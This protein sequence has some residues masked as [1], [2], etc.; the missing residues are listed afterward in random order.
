MLAQI[1]EMRDVISDL[2][3]LVVGDTDVDQVLLRERRV[4]E[5]SG[6]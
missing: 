4:R 6:N 3:S 1:S 5:H 2:D